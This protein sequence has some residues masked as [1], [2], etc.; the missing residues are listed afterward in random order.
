MGTLLLI[1]AHP[2]DAELLC[3]GT[4]K[5]YA[6]K[7]YK[8]YLLLATKG[9]QAVVANSLKGDRMTET[10]DAFKNVDINISCLNFP[11]GFLRQDYLLMTA[12]QKQ[13][14]CIRPTV[15]ITHNPGCGGLEHQDH[16]ELGKAAY[17]TAIRYGSDL[18]KILF[19][20]PL[21]SGF[22][23]FQPN[24]FIS[25]DK[26]Y[27]E[28]I[29]IIKSHVSQEEK[30]YMNERYLEMRASF[31]SPYITVHNNRF[32]GKFELFNQAYAVKFQ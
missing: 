4:V 6:E 8:C 20:Q 1:M 23:S 31:I 3:Y 2:D 26:Y 24:L 12:L 18:E 16:D 21:Y 25:I 14:E 28:K 17:S 15:I 11:D 10:R 5:R 27:K 29:E 22:T 30:F 32:G 19:A 13:I 7:G 9:E